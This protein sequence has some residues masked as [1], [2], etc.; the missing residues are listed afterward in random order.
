ME[1]LPDGE[2]Q[3][4]PPCGVVTEGALSAPWEQACLLSLNGG[5]AEEIPCLPQKE[6]R[7]MS[8]TGSRN[9]VLRL[10]IFMRHQQ[11]FKVIHT[12]SLQSL[13]TLMDYLW[14]RNL[15]TFLYKLQN[16]N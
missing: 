7:E 1:E 13:I 15:I 9:L 2:G 10:F 8:G 3:T 12:E 6:N 16:A 5:A 11:F 4:A 14:R